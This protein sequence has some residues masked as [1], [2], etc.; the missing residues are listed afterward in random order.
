MRQYKVKQYNMYWKILAIVGAFILL[1]ISSLSIFIRVRE[2][3]LNVIKAIAAC[4][5]LDS[6][7]DRRWCADLAIKQ[8]IFKLKLEKV[9]PSLG[10]KK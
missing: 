9:D 10:D 5:T 8:Y 6:D 7:Q 1:S 3:N 2:H 4:D